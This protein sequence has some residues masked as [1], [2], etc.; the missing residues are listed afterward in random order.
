MLLAAQVGL[1]VADGAIASMAGLTSQPS[2]NAIVESLRFTRRAIR[3]STRPRLIEMS[4]Y[5]AEVRELYAPFESGPRSPSAD[6]YELEMP[7]GQYTNLFQ[8]AK[9]LGLAVALAR[10]VQ[11]VFAGQPAFREHHQG[12]AELEG[13]RATWRFSWSPTT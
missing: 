1:D 11:G 6:L 2:L 7:G 4:R 8:Q 9:A 13:G 3:A 10:G 5:W 12:D